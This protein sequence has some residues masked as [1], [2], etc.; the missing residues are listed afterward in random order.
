MFLGDI[1]TALEPFV[2]AAGH[3]VK[4]IDDVADDLGQLALCVRWFTLRA[5]YDRETYDMGRR[6]R[7]NV[8]L[9]AFEDR[10]FADTAEALELDDDGDNDRAAVPTGG[11][12]Q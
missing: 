8:V 11:A 5:A 7:M 3:T 6:G 1:K 9:L 12:V 10:L 4:I 2:Q